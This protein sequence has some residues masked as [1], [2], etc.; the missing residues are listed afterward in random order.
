MKDGAAAPLKGLDQSIRISDNFYLI[1]AADHGRF[2]FCNGFLFSGRETVLIDAGIEASRLQEIDKIK[3]I[4][5]LIITHSHPDHILSWHVLKD[6]HILMPK[7]TPEDIFDL[8]R[9]GKRFMGTEEGGKYWAEYHERSL[10]LQPMRE[11]DER[12]KNGDLLEI[13]GAQ[14]TAIHA[15][16]HLKDHY[17]FLDRRSDFLIS[18]DIDFSPFGPMYANPE[19]DI[20]DLQKSV[21]KL[22]NLSFNRVCTSHGLPIEGDARR[23]FKEYFD[24]FAVHQK[25]VLDLCES[26]RTLE[27]MLAISPFYQN[28]FFDRTF[29]NTFERELIMKNLEQL[30]RKGL[31]EESEERYIRVDI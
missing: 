31:V 3:R 21:V 5:V 10:G 13:G 7:E 25:K 16:G 24:G 29:Q 20:Q 8:Y 14:L 27:E 18:T 4:D 30:I 6:R 23:Q 26:P 19:S 12:Y 28:K 2:P 17:C 9:L 15:P 11:P 22:K 1:K